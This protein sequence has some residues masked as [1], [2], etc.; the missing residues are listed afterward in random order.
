MSGILI[1]YCW[2]RTAYAAL[3][4][5][6]KHKY[7]VVLADSSTIGMSQMSKYRSKFIK[8]H[9]FLN[10]KEK[11]F[12]DIVRIINKIILKCICQSTMKLN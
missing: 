10:Q 2:V 3:L 4:N 1:S 11:F 12:N 5:L 9:E 8:V 7:D 6:A